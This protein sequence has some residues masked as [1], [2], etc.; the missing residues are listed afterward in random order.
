MQLKGCGF[1]NYTT[2]TTAVFGTH[3]YDFLIPPQQV[4]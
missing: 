2:N 4:E 3:W 1:T